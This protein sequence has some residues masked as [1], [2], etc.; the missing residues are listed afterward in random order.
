MRVVGATTGDGG[1]DEEING[2]YK[3][4]MDGG[5]EMQINNRPVYLKVN[6]NDVVLWHAEGKWRIGQASDKG[7]RICFASVL[8]DSK[9]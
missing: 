1:Y 8:A 4:C 2:D 6:S 3:K 7:S 5:G 9:S